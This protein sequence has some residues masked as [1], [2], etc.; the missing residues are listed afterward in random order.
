MS[1]FRIGVVYFAD[2]TMTQL[3]TAAAEAA[4]ATALYSPT[5]TTRY[6]T[7]SHNAADLCWQ[8]TKWPNCSSKNYV[9]VDIRHF[10]TFFFR[11]K[12]R[13]TPHRRHRTRTFDSSFLFLH[14]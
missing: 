13:H 4:A 6:L 14:P 11:F 9:S 2:F 8:K 7:Q 3:L 12:W 10:S 1:M 5:R